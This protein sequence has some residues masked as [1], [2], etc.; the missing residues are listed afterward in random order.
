MAGPDDE[1]EITRSEKEAQKDL[2]RAQAKK[3]SYRQGGGGGGKQRRMW[4]VDFRYNP[5][6]DYG[7]RERDMPHQ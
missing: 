5:Y 2:E 3:G 7:K 1:K 6:G 4:Q